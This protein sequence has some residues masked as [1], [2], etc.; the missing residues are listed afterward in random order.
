MT[1]ASEV[2]G[3]GLNGS[4]LP[5]SRA[6]SAARTGWTLKRVLVGIVG[7][8]VAMLLAVS[9]LGGDA[10]NDRRLWARGILEATGVVDLLFE[11][12]RN[13]ALERGLVHMALAKAE[14]VSA[15]DGASIDAHRR[16]A[17]AAFAEALRRLANHPAFAVDGAVIDRL[18]Q[19]H[20]DLVALRVVADGDLRN[21]AALRRATT[22][23]GWMPAASALIEATQQLVLVT[24]ALS[25]G[26][27]G[28]LAAL[29]EIRRLAWLINDVAGRERATLGALIAGGAPISPETKRELSALRA[30]FMLA[31]ESL[32]VLAGREDTAPRIAAGVAGLGDAMFGPFEATRQAVYQAGND[33]RPYPLPAAAWFATSTRAI[34]SALGLAEL[35]GGE[36]ASL[37]RESVA[38]SR[39]ILAV[40]LAIVAAGGLVLLGGVLF[41]DRRVVAPLN[42]AARATIE[43]A[44]GNLDIAVPRERRNNEIGRL[45]QALLRLRDNSVELARMAAAEAE[46][47]RQ[48]EQGRWSAEAASRMKSQFLANMSHEL[49]T[50]LNAIIGFSEVMAGEMLGPL[51]EPRYKGYARDIHESGRHLLDVI[52]DILDMSRVEAGK[53]ESRESAI[54]VESVVATAL[55]FVAERGAAAGLRVVTRVA[56][57]LP[58]LFADERMVKQILLNLLSNAIKFTPAGGEVTVSAAVEA[59]GPLLLAVADTGI[60]IAADDT[61]RAIEPFG[62]ID[63]DLNRRYQGTGLG[64]SLVKSLLDL[65]GGT[66]TLE[67][68]PGIGTVATVRFPADRLVAAPAPPSPSTSAA[69]RVFPPRRA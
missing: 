52:N 65:H 20:D 64:L 11:S 53:M 32:G 56:P 26:E 62:Q 67:S 3:P 19:R 43:L 28:R 63:S 22:T 59:A 45:S 14:P 54:D 42:A 46:L 37:A 17:D 40:V 23:A 47:K 31:W 66:L 6:P 60:G 35:A 13:W 16:T 15:E 9:Y 21:P 48:A 2:G 1:P 44:K 5:A 38:H 4:A 68:Q 50:P 57:G 25:E 51:G 7:S 49:R 61:Q 27:A 58:F 18:R 69:A 39:R 55:R 41:I 12:A 34:E 24:D 30:R 33:G 29:Q 10:V 36:I 8:L